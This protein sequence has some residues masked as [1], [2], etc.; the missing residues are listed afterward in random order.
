[1]LPVDLGFA[2][3][4]NC[5]L[6]VSPDTAVLAFADAAGHARVPLRIPAAAGFVGQVLFGQW[7]AQAAGLNAQGLAVS[8]GLRVVIGQ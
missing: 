5:P 8:T 3:M 2:G 7:I 4:P 6:Q 1:M